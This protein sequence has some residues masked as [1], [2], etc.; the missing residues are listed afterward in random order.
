MRFRRALGFGAVATL[1]AAAVWAQQAK[2]V[3]E[4][5]EGKIKQAAFHYYLG[6]VLGDPEEYLK[7]TRLPLQTVRNGKAGT[8]DDASA[9]AM[10]KSLAA[11]QAER[12]LTKEERTEVVGNIIRSLDDADVRFIG[13]NTATLVFMIRED[14]QTKSMLLCSLTLHRADPKA[15]E[16]KVVNETTDSDPVPADYVK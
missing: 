11:K 15:G 2:S 10:L 4:L 3:G 12:P 13:A 7:G 8:L 1:A 5:L 16:W 6:M 9:R 14:A